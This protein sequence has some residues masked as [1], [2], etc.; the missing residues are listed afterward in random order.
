MSPSHTIPLDSFRVTQLQKSY[1][2]DKE[3]IR[4][5]KEVGEASK[6]WTIVEGD[7]NN[8]VWA[9]PY[10]SIGPFQVT[11]QQK[12]YKLDKKVIRERRK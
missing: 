6:P 1:R 11:E 7:Y 3:V 9:L 4:G 12:S 8:W 2:L 5:E 10:N